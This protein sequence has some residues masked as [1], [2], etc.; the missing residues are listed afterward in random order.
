MGLIASDTFSRTAQSSGWGTSTGGQTWTQRQGASTSVKTSGTQGIIYS[1][2]GTRTHISAASSGGNTNQNILGRLT[3]SNVGD[4]FGIEGRM[5][6]IASSGG[7]NGYRLNYN[8]SGN[9]VCNRI[10]VGNAT[11]QGSNV[12]KTVTVST[13]YWFRLILLGGATNTTV[14][15]RMWADGSSEPATWD[16]NVTDSSAV[17]SGDPGFTGTAVNATGITCD[18]FVATDNTSTTSTRDISTRFRLQSASVLKDIST[19]FRLQSTNQAT[20]TQTRFRLQSSALLR[21]IGTRLRVQS[22]SQVK[23]ITARIRLQAQ[24]QKDVATRIRLQALTTRDIASRL[25]FQSATTQKDIA[26]RLRVQSPAQPRDIASRVRL[27][28]IS[29]RDLHTR[30]RLQANTSHDILARLRFQALSM[31]D[32]QSRVRLQSAPQTRDVLLRL[33]LAALAL[34]DMQTRFR[35][36]ALSLRDVHTR[37]RV[38]S[39]LQTR[40][41]SCLFRF[42]PAVEGYSY[43]TLSRAAGTVTL[44]RA[45]G[46]VTLERI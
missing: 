15:G 33:R 8:G 19:R 16:I 1:S 40:D 6:G 17:A 20:D 12:A 34:R 22:A 39:A 43:V 45:A 2:S 4:D 10:T 7:V 30:V 29:V 27:Q 36:Q 3:P 42:L 28:A 37:V 38:Q 13:A 46:T 11:Q 41:I 5:G 21:D 14:Q 32:V 24:G 25:R 26:S 18:N 35:L 31:R 44:S 9:L 23:D